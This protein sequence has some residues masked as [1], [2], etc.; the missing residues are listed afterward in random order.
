MYLNMYGCDNFYGRKF[1]TRTEAR[2]VVVEYIELLYNLKRLHS[3]RDI[4]SPKRDFERDYY[5][6]LKV[7]A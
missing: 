3:T 5:E 1:K 6:S 7:V 4:N 2:L